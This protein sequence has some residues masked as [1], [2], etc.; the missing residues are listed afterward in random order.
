MSNAV[1]GEVGGDAKNKLVQFVE[2][3]I[4]GPA[5][6]AQPNR[7]HEERRRRLIDV[8]G[9]IHT[10]MTRLRR[11]VSAEEVVATFNDRTSSGALDALDR[12]AS[13]LDLPT[14]RELRASF[15]ERAQALGVRLR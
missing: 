7:L 15:Q 5:M 10:E 11:C 8:Q 1:I 9:R 13:F 6:A 14:M 12:D 2:R 4:H 3:R